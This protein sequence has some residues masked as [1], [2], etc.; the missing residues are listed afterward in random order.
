MSPLPDHMPIAGA[1]AVSSRVRRLALRLFAAAVLAAWLASGL[2]TVGPNETGV[3]TRFGRLQ[4]KCSPGIHYLTPWPIDR[5]VAV[6]VGD[7]RRMEVGFHNS[8]G[9]PDDQQPWDVL[10]GD[11]NILHLTMVVQYK[12]RHADE[13]LFH[14][15]MPERLVERA[16]E[17]TM[18]ACVARLP[19]D[20]VLTTAKQRMQVE[21]IAEAQRLLD[22][23]GGGIVLLSGNLQE[24]TPPA[25]VVQAFKEVAS[26]M[27]DAERDAEEAREYAGRTV[28]RADGDAQSRIARAHGYRARRVD[29]AR[30]DAARFIS[31]L[32][33]YRGAENVTRTR[34]FVD[35]MERILRRSQVVILGDHDPTAGNITIVDGPRGDSARAACGP[36]IGIGGPAPAE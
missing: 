1:T 29:M 34:L 14:I 7:V 8:S 3:V 11:E 27:K 17:S 16:V 2:H 31:L 32:A 6:G 9:Y 18:N 12:I 24:V 5:L 4:A 22:A 19:V 35:S 10:T 15:E 25:S 13:Y 26:A 28:L 21:I 20:E 23:C 30:G 36:E 33:D